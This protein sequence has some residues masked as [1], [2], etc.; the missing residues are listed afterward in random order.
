MRSYLEKLAKLNIGWNVRPLGEV[1]FYTLCRRFRIT[2]VE[3]PL[4]TNGFYYCVKSKHFIA[5]SSRLPEIRKL[6]VM[7]HEFA[8][9]LMHSPDTNTTASFHGLGKKTR[10]EQEADT[11]ALCALIP[12]IWL[13]GREISELIDD[14]FPAEL[15]AER[16]RI[17]E[18][19]GL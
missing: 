3:M 18:R 17:Y 2:V 10:K 6:L 19:L 7:F 9:F 4:E 12:K 11:F 15:L 5:V 13:E 8:H 1:D 14:G 16:V